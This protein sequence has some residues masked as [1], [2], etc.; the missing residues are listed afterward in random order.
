M[1]TCKHK[2][3]YSRSDSYWRFTGRYTREYYH[4][5]YYFCEKCL[6]EKIVEKKHSCS[7]NGLYDLPEWAKTITKR[8]AGYE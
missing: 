1:S 7:D 5:D 6:E 3:I 2:W 4:C 8:V